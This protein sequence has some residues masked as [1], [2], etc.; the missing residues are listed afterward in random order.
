MFNRPWHELLEKMVNIMIPEYPLA[1]DAYYDDQI[2][3]V[4]AVKAA[5]LK[6]ELVHMSMVSL[7]VDL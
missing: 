4:Y 7:T 5:K 3:D 2:S 6:G 1:S